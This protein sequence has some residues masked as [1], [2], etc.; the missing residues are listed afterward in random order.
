MGGKKKIPHLTFDM[1]YQIFINNI[2]PAPNK[3]Q[4]Q[5]WTDLLPNHW[6]YFCTQTTAILWCKPTDNYKDMFVGQTASHVSLVP[7]PGAFVYV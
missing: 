2:P 1:V 7:D 3:I 5:P 4:L 6:L